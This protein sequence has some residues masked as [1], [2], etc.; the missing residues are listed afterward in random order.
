MTTI[1]EVILTT[2]TTSVG[3]IAIVTYL[4]KQVFNKVL[5]VGLE[6]YKGKLKTDLEQF[7]GQL[8]TKLETHKSKLATE[9][10]EFKSQ[11]NKVA[12]EHQIRF[13]KLHADRAMVIREMHNKIYTLEKS[14]QHLTTLF[15]GPEW[16]TDTTREEAATTSLNDLKDYIELNRIFFE[17]FFCQELEDLIN[18]CCAIVDGMRAAKNQEKRNSQTPESTYIS[19]EKLL[20]PLDKWFELNDKVKINLKAKRLEIVEKF[21]NLLGIESV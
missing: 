15:Q 5:D 2:V 16:V 20:N 19:R 6:S 18:D 12:T 21:R 17:E 9:T 11:L 3:I 10:E 4:G 1:V 13:L 14:M 7:K 8:N